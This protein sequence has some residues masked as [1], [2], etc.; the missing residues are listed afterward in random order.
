MILGAILIIIGAALLL[1]NLGY[2]SEGA[3]GIIWPAILIVIG[4]GI[5]LKKRDDGIF[6]E[7]GFGWRKKNLKKKNK[8]KS[9]TFLR[10]ISA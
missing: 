5:I 6:W 4:I 8:N 1:E 9:S 7:E 10:G 2:I 3:G